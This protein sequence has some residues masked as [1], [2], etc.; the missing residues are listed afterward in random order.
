MEHEHVYAMVEI[1]DG[2]AVLCAC[3]FYA[4]HLD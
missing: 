1:E 3:G 4:E 2:F